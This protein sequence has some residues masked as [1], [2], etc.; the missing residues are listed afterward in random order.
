MS[1]VAGFDVLNEMY[2]RMNEAITVPEL[3][4]PQMLDETSV[5]ARHERCKW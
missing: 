2:A 5:V 3:W 1:D 4:T